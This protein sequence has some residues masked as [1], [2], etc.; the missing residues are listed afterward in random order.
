MVGIVTL[1]TP[2]WLDNVGDALDELLGGYADD[3]LYWRLVSTYG[4]VIL[5]LKSIYSSIFL[6]DILRFHPALA[7]AIVVI[8]TDT[9]YGI[10]NIYP[11]LLFSHP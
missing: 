5:L 2:E 6:L 8:S 3:P 10:R 4:F 1:E 11:P 7:T 9:S